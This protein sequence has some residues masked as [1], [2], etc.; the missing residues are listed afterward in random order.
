MMKIL[1]RRFKG[2]KEYKKTGFYSQQKMHSASSS[3]CMT[4]LETQSRLQKV[5]QHLVKIL[6]V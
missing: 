4:T 3:Q 6:S 1:L 5:I 2:D